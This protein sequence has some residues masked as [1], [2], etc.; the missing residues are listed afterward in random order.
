MGLTKPDDLKFP[1]VEDLDNEIDSWP[2]SISPFI[3]S[4]EMH[5]TDSNKVGAKGHLKTNS[6]DH[7]ANFPLLNAAV[8]P[9]SID[10]I[11]NEIIQS[12]D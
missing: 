6:T 9:K 7:T 4:E 10:T 11:V 12:K 2:D 5:C 8:V 3:I 1:T